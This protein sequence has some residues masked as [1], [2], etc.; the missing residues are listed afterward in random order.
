MVENRK[1]REEEREGN[2]NE[3]K[4]EMN[5]DVKENGNTNKVTVKIKSN[6]SK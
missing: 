1:K 3:W 4:E 5:K 6:K 2:T